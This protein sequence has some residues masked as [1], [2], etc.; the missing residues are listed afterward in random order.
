MQKLK[1]T[2]QKLILL[3]A[4]AAL[5]QCVLTQKQQK[6]F[7]SRHCVGSDSTVIQ[8]EI[9]FK[10]TTFYITEQGPIQYLENPC[11]KLCDSLG[12]LKPFSMTEK[13]NGIKTTIKSIGNSISINSETDSLEAKAKTKETINITSSK[14][15][16]AVPVECKQKHCTGWCGFTNYW[17]I[18]TAALIVLYTLFKCF[19]AYLKT[20]PFIR[21]FIK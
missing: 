18:I 16:K 2:I 19:K 21:I 12:N 3:I 10:D 5:S 14:I 11:K 8:H 7:L 13:K 15:V 9:I 20:V 4:T 6:R 1:G 17:F